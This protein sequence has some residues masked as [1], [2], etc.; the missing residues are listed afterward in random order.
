MSE[1]WAN[2]QRQTNRMVRALAKHV[3]AGNEVTPSHLYGLSKLAWITS[4]YEGNNPAYIQSTKIPALGDVLDQDF[5][6]LSLEKIASR[7]A[8]ITG[9]SEIEELVKNHSGFTNFYKAYRNS[10]RLWF[11]RNHNKLLP[12]FVKAYHSSTYDDR[13]GLVRDIEN[14][15][16]IPKPNHPEQLMRPEYLLTPALFALDPEIQLPLINGNDWVKNV[17]AALKVTDSSLTKQFSAMSQLIGQGGIRDAADLDQVGRGIPEEIADFLSTGK[18]KRSKKLLGKKQIK[19][20][21]KN[22]SLKDE[23]DIEAIKLAGTVKHRSIHNKLTNQLRQS[24][25]KYLL[26]EGENP[27]CMYDILVKNYDGDGND[28]LIEAKSSTEAAH[29]RMAVGQLYHYWFVLKNDLDDCHLAVLLPEAPTS[30]VKSF[31]DEL[32]IGLLWFNGKGIKTSTT[33]LKNFLKPN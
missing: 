19:A 12:L 33:W 26:F 28:L 7:C 5:S 13:L 23:S 18:K 32:D 2:R 6:G 25:G 3:L 8:D 31:L 30:S 21:G 4:S 17:L 22:L 11:E 14:L 20:K 16:G 10:S 9:S 1:N 15:P 27:A 24:L 29:V